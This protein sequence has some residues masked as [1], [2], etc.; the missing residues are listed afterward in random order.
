MATSDAAVST[1]PAAQKGSAITDARLLD[2]LAK[3]WAAHKKRSLEVRMEIGDLLN[4][5][6]GQPTGRQRRGRS[7]LK[8]ASRT[9]Q[10]AASELNR[11]RWFAHFGKDEQSCWGDT[12]PTS[13]SWT[14]FKA[15]LP[16][17]LATLKG[18]GKRQRSSG[19]IKSTAVVD[20]VLRSLS[21]ATSK[22]RASN[23]TVDGAKKEELIGRLREFVLAVSNT[24]GVR[25]LVET[26]ENG[27]DG[28]T[29]TIAAP[30]YETGLALSQC[31]MDAA[32]VLV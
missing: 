4:D 27:S 19:E 5:R 12:D 31:P 21:S 13:R 10:I 8:Q 1:A 16:G 30:V 11:M 18:N 7:V 14:K 6:L 9:M 24:C 17:L 28:L 23:F 32:A 20:S 3:L 15:I 2:K 26:E 22:L 29:Q 25:F